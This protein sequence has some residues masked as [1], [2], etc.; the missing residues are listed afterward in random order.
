MG[1]LGR[2]ILRHW[3]EFRPTDVAAMRKAGHL[4]QTMKDLED[5]GALLLRDLQLQGF[6]QVEASELLAELVY[7]P[8][9]QDMPV[10]GED[11]DSR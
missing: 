9:E 1:D 3:E 11:P 4:H 8:S 10:L 7:P 2:R 6:N 5:R